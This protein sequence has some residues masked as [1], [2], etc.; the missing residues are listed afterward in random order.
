[1]TFLSPALL[2]GLLALSV[3]IIIHFFNLQ[4]PREVLFSNVAFVR[5]V[6]KTVVRRLKFKQWF[7]LL[8]RLLA[9]ALLVMA[10]ARPTILKDN[11]EV[12]YGG[13]SVAIIIDNSYSMKAGNEKG[14]YFQQSISLCRSIIKAYDKQSEFLIMTGSQPRLNYDFG[15][16]E[17]ALEELGELNIKQNDLNLKDI[18]EL[19]EDIFSK[20]GFND[21]TLI[22][23]SDFQ[24][25]TIMSES[26][27]N[28]KLDS[29]IEVKLIPLA[30]RKQ[31]NVYIKDH[32]IDS[33]VLEKG[34]PVAMT[35]T[36]TNDSEENIKDVNVRVLLEGKAVAINNTEVERNNEKTLELSFTPQQSGWISGE[37]QIDD[38][39]ID[40]DNVRYFSL[41]IPEAE[42]V[43]VLEDQASSN[44]RLLYKN[45]FESFE[46]EVYPIRQAAT[47]Q[48][49]DYKSIILV[50]I[51]DL[52]SGLR[53]KLSSFL[54]EGGSILFFPGD[55][56]NLQNVNSFFQNVKI[57]SFGPARRI[58]A[59]LPAKEVE[60]DHPVFDGIFTDSK[61]SRSFDA[62]QVFQHYPL[63]TDNSVIQNK[64]LQ[65][66]SREN[67]LLESRVGKGLF[68]TFTIFPGD[69]WTDF[70]VKSIFLPLMFRITQ[71]MNQSGNVLQGQT[72]GKF[73]PKSLRVGNNQNLISLQDKDGNTFTP[74]QYIQ[75]GATTLNFSRIELSE[76]NYS[77]IQEEK[78]LEKIS[79]NI[80]DEESRL[81]FE[82]KKDLQS[83]FGNSIDILEPQADSIA[84]GIKQEK[85]GIPLW[86]YFIL[87]ALLFLIL[88]IIVLQLRLS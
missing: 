56:M 69:N 77:L 63:K 7:L 25:S 24:N 19:K 67:I 59:G 52:N 48:L 1:M 49:S 18:L 51:T 70:H 79:F 10:F 65:L 20:S 6:K 21:K 61:N 68:Y 85:E 82:G 87:G 15:T 31:K 76:G 40:F 12:N 35:L 78:L 47:V 34:K 4:R 36:L 9:L 23:M 42:K 30:S 39:P 66:E 55:E 22:I 27:E 74:E 86:K 58:Q 44:V 46:S 80:S 60:L 53:E 88:E 64:I 72:I 17:E 38:N 29:S 73:S 43:L 2:W 26:L 62:P 83:R 3:P 84:L 11:K 54:E 32:R 33:R 81:E 75:G 50:G 16:L 13:N 37:I 45:L 28:I 57:G 8:L 5:E 71:I 14:N 41:Y